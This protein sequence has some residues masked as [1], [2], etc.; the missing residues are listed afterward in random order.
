MATVQ[1]A[2]RL[3]LPVVAT[4]LASNF[5]RPTIT[6]PTG[7][8]VCISEG[9]I[10]ANPGVCA[11]GA[12]FQNHGPDGGAVC[13]CAQRLANSV[14]IARRCSL[15]LV[16]GKP[17]PDF[18]DSAVDGVVMSVPR[19]LQVRVARGLKGRLI[20]LPTPRRPR[21][22]GQ[23]PA[24]C[25][26]AGVRAEHHSEDGISGLRLPDRVGLHQ[27]A[28]GK[29]L[30]DGARSEFRRGLAGG[31]CAAD[32]DL[33]PLSTTCAE[34]YLNPRQVQHA[35]SIPVGHP[36]I[37]P[38]CL[39]IPFCPSSFHSMFHF[40]H[41]LCSIPSSSFIEPAQ[42]Q[43]EEEIKTLIELA[44][45]LE[46]MTRNI[47]MH[48]GGVLIRP[49]A[50]RLLPAC[51]SSPAAPRRSASTTR[52]MEAV[53]LVKF[54]FLGLATLTILE[55]AREFIIRRH[56]G[57]EKFCLLRTCRWTTAPP[58]SCFRRQDRGGVQVWNRR[59]CRKCS[60]DAPAHPAGRP[61]LR[62]TRCTAQPDGP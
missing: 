44:Q 54:D 50:D 51:T 7:P 57:Q 10:L 36:S 53:G 35:I 26:Q 56:P 40:F 22:R 15:T 47:G 30:P 55:I 45:K 8:R 17:V 23:P 58:T 2:A 62:G 48:A 28:K 60:K 13:R 18:P 11:R 9:E 37:L 52:T 39:S 24:V 59:A 61:R 6:R 41:H 16:L 32:L 12:V 5:W 38:S 49:Q 29:R 21:R 31:V 34:R 27:W 42:P 46:G 25:G 1:L 4:H 3:S 14:E 20:H 33:D 19:L 43:Q